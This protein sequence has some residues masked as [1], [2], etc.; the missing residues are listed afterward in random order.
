MNLTSSAVL[1]ASAIT[2][3][4]S[5]VSAQYVLTSGDDF[6]FDFNTASGAIIDGTSNAYDE[7]PQLWIAG[8][9][10]SAPS[11]TTSSDGRTLSLAPVQIGSSISAQRTVFVP[12]NGGNY[13]VYL[14]SFTNTSN[15][16]SNFAISYGTSITNLGDLGS[17]AE[18]VVT[19]SSS[20]DTTYALGDFWFATD[21]ATP[22]FTGTDSPALGH[23]VAGPGA[24]DLPLDSRRPGNGDRFQTLY[25][26]NVP[27]GETYSYLF[28]EIQEN[29]RELAASVSA[30]LTMNPDVSF[31]TADQI[32]TIR[33]FDIV[34][35]EPASL[36]LLSM[37]GLLLLRRRK[38]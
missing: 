24:A 27:A 10:Y 6:T 22:G 34:V 11:A 30:D 16:N 21:D 25:N 26:I 20:G 13:A 36:G 28:F 3:A 31:L 2:F 9:N 4:A 7:F 29:T 38:A 14:N 5:S 8:T 37:S 1:A 33:N 19:A 12:E 32:G 15:G 23:V 17:D 35:P 18:T